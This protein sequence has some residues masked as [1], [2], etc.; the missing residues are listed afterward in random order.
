MIHQCLIRN[1]SIWKYSP[2]NKFK[3][4]TSLWLQWR[5]ETWITFVSTDGPCPKHPNK[6]YSLKTTCVPKFSTKI[7]GV[8]THGKWRH[9]D[10][11]MWEFEPQNGEASIWSFDIFAGSFLFPLCLIRNTVDNPRSLS[12]ALSSLQS[13]CF[14][15][16][17][18]LYL[19]NLKVK[20]LHKHRFTLWKSIYY[21]KAH[22]NPIWKGREQT[23]PLSFQRKLNNSKSK[24]KLSW[25]TS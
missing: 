13:S 9:G 11:A 23:R 24:I 22:P 5:L 12:L 17:K 25:L 19:W 6:P 21:A 15:V 10:G 16:N 4:K 8:N 14:F 20:L 7:A 3:S 2:R 1:L 18:L